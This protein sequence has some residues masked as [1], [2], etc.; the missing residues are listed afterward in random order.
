MIVL[1][2]RVEEIWDEILAIFGMTRAASQ[3]SVKRQVQRAR[4]GAVD[5]I[6]NARS[7]LL[8]PLPFKFPPTTFLLTERKMAF[9]PTEL[10]RVRYIDPFVSS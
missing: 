3:L 10:A 5:H 6:K 7:W 2:G 1:G 4:Q 8:V 9:N